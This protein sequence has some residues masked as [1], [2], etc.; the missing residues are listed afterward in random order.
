[1]RVIRAKR[2]EENRRGVT[3]LYVVKG[4]ELKGK[5]CCWVGGAQSGKGN[6]DH[7]DKVKMAN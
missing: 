7:V 1:M 3:V 6:L 4:K 5:T 2:W